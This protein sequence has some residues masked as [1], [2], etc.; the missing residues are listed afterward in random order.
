MSGG[1]NMDSMMQ[2]V[3]SMMR[4]KSNPGDAISNSIL[5]IQLGQ[6][7]DKNLLKSVT[8]GMMEAQK[9]GTASPSKTYTATYADEQPATDII[10]TNCGCF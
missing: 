2:K 6:M 3:Q 9:N 1:S 7:S 5:N 10:T 4:G 8:K